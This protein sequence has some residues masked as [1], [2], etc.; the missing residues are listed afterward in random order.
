MGDFVFFKLINDYFSN[1][2]QT[3]G[4]E[5]MMPGRSVQGSA[6]PLVR[7]MTKVT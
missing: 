3:F 7:A 6:S 4:L 5:L 2:I 1:E